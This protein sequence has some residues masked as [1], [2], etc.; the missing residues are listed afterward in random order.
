MALFDDTLL[1]DMNARSREVF[2]QIVDAY[3]ETGEPIGSRS[4]ARRMSENLSAATIRNVMSDLEEMG[5]LVAPHISAG[6]LPSEKGLR[7]FVNALMEVGDLPNAERDQLTKNCEQ[8]GYSLDQM[9]GEATSML[10]GLSR[11]A[12]LVVAPKTDGIRLKQIEFVA[13]SPGK[14][15]AVLVSQTGNVENRILDVPPDL[16]T[17]ALTEASNYLNTRLAGKT[18][19]DA[20]QLMSLERDRIKQE[21]DELSAGLIDAGLAT[22]AGGVKGSSLIVKGQSQ[23]LE[24]IDTIEQLETV[25]RLFNVLEARDQMIELLDVTT[26]AQGVQIFIG[27][28]NKLFGGSGLSM[29]ISPYQ[30][31]EGSI[32]GAIGVVG[33]TRI[34][35]ARI[36]PLVDYTAKLVGRL[37]G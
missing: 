26:I 6:R 24:N 29:V 18:L 28:E 9:L 20:R 22:W 25:R 15:L 35:Y 16:P 31:A 30:N 2:R 3:V 32:V 14:V 19:D 10:S 21:L 27:S 7:L 8:A 13:L 33:P 36:I 4:I 17:S 34:N 12:G 1:G 23:L 5:L 37:I 11:C